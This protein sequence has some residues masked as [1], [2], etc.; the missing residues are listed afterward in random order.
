MS[1]YGLEK[2]QRI[3]LCESL[4]RILTKGAVVAGEITL[5]VANIELLYVGLQLVLTSV[6]RARELRTAQAPDD[7]S[8]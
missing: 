2:A 1:Q 6:E 5:S 4:D 3:S 8:L 7:H